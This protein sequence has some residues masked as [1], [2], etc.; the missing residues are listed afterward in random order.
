VRITISAV[1]D[2]ILERLEATL[3]AAGA[4]KM[5]PDEFILSTEAMIAYLRLCMQERRRAVAAAVKEAAQ[6]SV[7]H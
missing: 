6:I 1:A 4:R 3:L 7:R 5:A 2:D